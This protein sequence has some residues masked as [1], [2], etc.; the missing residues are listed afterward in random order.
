MRIAIL[1]DYQDQVRH[2]PCFTRLAGH[3]VTILTQSEPD[4]ERLAA[5]LAGV[6]ALVLIRERTRIDEALLRRL[7]SLRLI[8]QTGKI[9]QHIDPLLCQRHGVAVA[10]GIG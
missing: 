3:D 4:P 1:D 9:S 2:L 5:K 8:S 6:E 7:P 10:E